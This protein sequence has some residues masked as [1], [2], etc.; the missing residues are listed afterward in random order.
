MQ[1]HLVAVAAIALAGCGSY[2]ATSP[3]PDSTATAGYLSAA[4]HHGAGQ[5]PRRELPLQELATAMSSAARYHDV[6]K[7][8][9]DGYQDI[10]VVLPNMGRHFLKDGLLDARFEADRP[11]L[12]VYTPDSTVLVALEYAV[13]I[14]LSPSAPEGFQGSADQWVQFG[15]TLWTLHAW[16][17]KDNPDG[18]FNPTNERV[19]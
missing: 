6:R 12:L 8:L 17:W 15:G 18:L 10:G 3:A 5:E 1:Y 16:V 11:E 7:A 14:A 2:D 13:P 4:R 19:P 9:A